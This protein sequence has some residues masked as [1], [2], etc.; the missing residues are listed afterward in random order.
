[1]R[2]LIYL[3]FFLPSV[4][5]SQTHEKH[6][7]RD[8]RL[9]IELSDGILHLV[10]LSE[11]VVRVQWEKNGIREEQ[12]FVIIN[13]PSI[14]KFKYSETPSQLRL[15]TTMLTV[16]FNKQSG[17]LEFMNKLGKVFL[18]EKAG[19]RKLVA[20]T[21]MGEQCFI[22][23][24]SFN[25]PQGEN[26]FGLG[27]F[28]DGNFDLRNVSR[29]LAQ[30]NSQIAIPFLYSSNNYGIL[31]HQY[32]LTY[33]NPADN[34]VLLEK[35][36]ASSGE[37][38]DVEVTTT[39]GT[40][41]VSQQQA[42]YN[43]KFRVDRDGEYSIMLDLGDMDNRHLVAIDGVAHIDQSNLWLPPSAG[44]L[45]RLK[46][47]EHTVQIVCKATN[48]P[49]FSWKPTE[50][51]TTFRSPHAKSLDYVVFSGKDADEVIANYR[52]LSG[53]VPML[54]LWAYGF[55]QCRERYTSGTH[56]V[57]TVKEFRKRNLPMDVI[58]QDWQYWG[59]YGWGVPKFDE[60]HYPEP[61]KF[62]KELHDLNA[63]F[64]VSVWE[65]IDKKSEVAKKYL[66]NGLYIPNSPWIDIYNPKTQ[67]THWNALNDNLFS[68]GVDSWWMDATEPENDALAGKK[69]F[70]GL[71]NFYRLT[72][73]L[74]VSK[75]VYEGQ[76]QTDPNK[77]VAILT[78]SAFAGQQRYGT[79]NWSGDIGWNWDTFKRQI[80]AGLN[81]NLTG[82][83]YWTTD[84][85][86][87]FRP[88]QSQYTDEKYHD[89][90][91]RWFQWGAFNPVFRIHGY[92]SE[93]EPWK[94]GE[95]VEG[96][97]RKM[98]NLRY[99]L[100][101]YI[102]SAAWKVSRNGST[103]MRPLV[104]DFNTDPK[105]VRQGY[106]YMFGKSMLVAPVTEAGVSNW[107]VY[108]PNE[109]VWYD[110]WTGKKFNGG[111]TL[112]A[113]ASGDKIPVFVK[114]GSIIPI[115]NVMQYTGQA[116]ADTL[117]I[118]VYRGADGTFD[119]YEDEGDNYNYENAKFT[120]I[121]F[122]WNESSGSLSIGSLQGSFAG[123]L[124]KR[125]FKVVAVKQGVGV[126]EGDRV[127]GKFIA[128]NGHSM[129]IRLE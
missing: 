17:N 18:S 58:V 65:N 48:T 70:F 87:F 68:L 88:G 109:S 95:K 121:P 38:G 41:R 20:D 94:Y 81:F 120:L 92:Q 84:I 31:W 115:G 3:L 75:A 107:D 11:K 43:G 57:E 101:P 74:F 125:V 100:M 69:T 113:D 97:M 59:K 45:V 39:S 51:V 44:K 82:M 25:S 63:R 33:F 19:S 127:A 49:K 52:N 89:I 1:M 86:G 27:Q 91:L 2:T 112:K 12:Q 105:A 53:N 34:E 102:Y 7:L 129:S 93:T 24:Q 122:K 35:G 66:E 37:K 29:K 40:Q 80:V 124:K 32:G 90:L 114:G 23:E 108:L 83:P 111:Q 99:R 98:L 64:S 26:L 36:T 76:R 103:M 126:T 85:G 14:P 72:Y 73:P 8:D 96:A 119:L 106:E 71:G 60:A 50:D 56:L 77:R 15:S 9:S 128:Y 5:L 61:A 118:R 4:V 104:M 13:K 117:E 22:A 42:V 47:G 16:V 54:P 21:V 30:V 46:A 55:W 10:P 78:R 6:S 79:I 116:S 28:Q 67:K 123:S 110:L 62:I